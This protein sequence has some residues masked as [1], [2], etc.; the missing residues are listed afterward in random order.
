MPKATKVAITGHAPNSVVRPLHERNIDYFVIES[1]LFNTESMLESVK[2]AL[3]KGC[4]LFII[5]H[6]SNVFG[7]IA[8]I[9]EIDKL[10]YDANAGMILDASQSAGNRN[11]DVSKLKSIK[12]ACM[13]GHKGLLGISGTGLLLVCTDESFSPIM[14]GGTGSL[15]NELNQPEI[16]PDRLE[17]GTPNVVGIASLGAGMRAILSTGADKIGRHEQLLMQKTAD[18]LEKLED[19]QVFRS[20]NDKNQCGV[21]SF[22]HKNIACEKIAEFLADNGICVRAGLHCAPLAHKSAGTLE[23]G[24]VRVSFGFH[25]TNRDVNEFILQMRR[26]VE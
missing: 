9:E 11:I 5:N 16:L 25:N 15:S 24:T 17:S 19:I 1:E 10:L 23:T 26:F 22:R 3:N 8:P 2:A 6:V 4:D 7:Q 12:A 21:L 18:K 14:Q 20:K 13:A